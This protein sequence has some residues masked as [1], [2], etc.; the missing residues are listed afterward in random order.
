MTRFFIFTLL[1]LALFGGADSISAQ[2]TPSPTPVQKPQFEEWKDDFSGAKLDEKL[3]EKFTFE[4][5]GGGKLEIKDGELHIRSGNKTRAGVRSVNSF[6][7]E[8]F[9]VEAQVAKAGAPFPEPGN[10]SILPGFAN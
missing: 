3:W 6:T 1:I 7:G 5:G 10:N 8:R 9:I 2:A 4:G